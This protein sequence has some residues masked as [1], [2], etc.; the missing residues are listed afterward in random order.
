[1][2]TEKDELHKKYLDACSNI[3]IKGLEEYDIKKLL[4]N[5]TFYAQNLKKKNI[6]K[7]Y[8]FELMFDLEFQT[9]ID[10]QRKKDE[11]VLLST[12]WNRQDHD[13]YWEK[14]C[15]TFPRNTRISF[16]EKKI[17]IRVMVKNCSIKYMLQNVKE[18]RNIKK[19][20]KCIKNKSHKLFLSSRLLKI[21]KVDQFLK[22]IDLKPKIAICFFD[23]GFYENIV[24][25]YLKNR[26]A[27]TI[28]NQH[29]QPVFKSH[30]FDRMNQSQILNFKC[31]YYLA[32]GEFTKKQ[33]VN[34]GFDEKQIV[35]IGSFNENCKCQ[36]SNDEKKTFC[37]FLNGVG[38][39]GV[40]ETNRALLDI[41]AKLSER[42]GVEYYIKLH[43][44]DNIDNYKWFVHQGLIKMV[45]NDMSIT[46]IAEKID[47]GI[48]NE[49][50]VYLDL[51]SNKLHSYRW[52]NGCKFPLVEDENCLF[53]NI[54]E[55]EKKVKEW[56]NSTIENKEQ[57]LERISIYY[58]GNGDAS[59]N[60]KTFTEEI[61]KENM[62]QNNRI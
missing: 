11:I 56:M 47:F 43:P 2:I 42:L 62:V 12:K 17:S 36:Y 26:G 48:F 46:E 58:N 20:L 30:E 10:I 35:V 29:G 19:Q 15:N 52:D 16:S 53:T 1:M 28:T 13:E 27:I 32:K 60:I 61:L 59:K 57:Y 31:D 7:R 3:V 51:L 22:E 4:F 37:T 23:S 45:K 14:I 24:M 8:I 25:Q 34:A 49:S 44:L 54:D 6:L 33:F 18:I 41:S 40:E 39:P 55:L 5:E 38:L 50:G 21:K 9:H